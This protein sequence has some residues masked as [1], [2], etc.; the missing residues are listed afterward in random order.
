MQ[1]TIY[2][3]IKL[4]FKDNV[5][6]SLKILIFYRLSNMITNFNS[7]YWNSRNIL[8]GFEHLEWEEVGKIF[9]KIKTCNHLLG[10]VQPVKL[11]TRGPSNYYDP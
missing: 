2:K 1:K 5:F 9:F 10:L 6:I 4:N 11:A 7:C 3:N 8:Y